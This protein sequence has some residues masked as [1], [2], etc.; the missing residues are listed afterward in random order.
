M[1]LK[2]KKTI[3]EDLEP[4]TDREPSATKVSSELAQDSRAWSAAVQDVVNSIGDADSTH[5]A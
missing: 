1:R 5:N 2:I 3:K 4:R